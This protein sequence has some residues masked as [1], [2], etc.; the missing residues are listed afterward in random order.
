MP[1]N[2]L[3]ALAI[4]F[5]SFSVLAVESAAQEDTYEM[6]FQR[7]SGRL[8]IAPEFEEFPQSINWGDAYN[9]ERVAVLLETEGSPLR[10]G[11]SIFVFIITDVP[12]AALHADYLRVE[13]ADGEPVPRVRFEGGGGT[14]APETGVERVD[15]GMMFDLTIPGEY[16]VQYRV[17]TREWRK[18]QREASLS[19]IRGEANVTDPPMQY[20]LQSPLVRFTIIE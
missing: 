4:A 18:A 20:G 3:R 12:G 5:V 7:F 13:S 17:P 1:R 19:R 9:G 6:L 10:A 15:L 2:N 16:V 8:A 14:R 11:R